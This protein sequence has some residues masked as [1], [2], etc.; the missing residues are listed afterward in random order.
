MMPAAMRAGA[1][2]LL[3]LPYDAS[4]SYRRG[5][6]AAPGVIR[7][8]FRS[9]SSNTWSEGL[10]DIGRPDALADAGDLALPSAATAAAEARALIETGVRAILDRGALPLALGGDHSVTYPILRTLA[11]RHPGLAVLHVDAH[12]DL[13][14]EYQGDRW[15]H[16]CPF[17]RVMEDGLARRLVQ[18]GIRTMNG[19]QQAQAERFGVEVIDMRAWMRGQRPAID[20]PV[21]VS[22]DMDGFDPAFAPGVSHREPGGLGARDVIDII[23]SLGGPVVGA[24]VVEF[25]PAEDLGDLT[26]RLCAKLVKELVGRML[27]TRRG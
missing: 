22:I 27:E 9:D 15:S 11:P 12:P 20:G 16:A 6:A 3:G 7:A 2:T 14:E 25:N 26:A 13:Y 23:Q 1:P 19:H 4:S 17:A 10:R 5:A 8:A 18:V 21:Y 24:D